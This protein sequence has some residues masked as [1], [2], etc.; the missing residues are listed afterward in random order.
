MRYDQEA[1]EP[2]KAGNW[3]EFPAFSWHG[4][5]DDA[6]KWALFTLYHR[7]SD[8]LDRSNGAAILA[9]LRGVDPDETNWREERHNHFL[10]GW[11]TA[12]AF[13]PGTRAGAVVEELRARMV[14]Y[15]VLDDEAYYNTMYTESIETLAQCFAR[16][17][18]TQ[19]NA[20]AVYE[21]LSRNGRD[22]E[23]KDICTYD[24]VFACDALGF[25]PKDD[26]ESGS[27]DN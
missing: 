13:R 5:P 15:P 27:G 11:L 14:D 25:T 1:L 9:A 2:V 26:D 24:V 21:W 18:V 3:R 8:T 20:N 22:V 17:G 23:A 6:E 4:K 10:V 12:I 19:E 7:D 16:E